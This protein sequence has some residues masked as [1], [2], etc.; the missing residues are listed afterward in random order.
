MRITRSI[1]RRFHPTLDFMSMQAENRV[2]RIGSGYQTLA[3]LQSRQ[4]GAKGIGNLVNGPQAG[5]S[6]RARRVEE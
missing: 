4:V 2:D 6:L 1:M 5:H 3:L